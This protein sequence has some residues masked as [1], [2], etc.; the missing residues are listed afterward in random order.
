MARSHMPA[1]TFALSLP[2]PTSPHKQETMSATTTTVAACQTHINTLLATL[3]GLEREHDRRIS[4]SSKPRLLAAATWRLGRARLIIAE[5]LSEGVASDDAR[6]GRKRMQAQSE[7]R[8]VE[9][10]REDL[11]REAVE[12]REKREGYE[13]RIEEWRRRM[14][15]LV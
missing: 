8:L 2:P 15:E 5:L 6:L 9:E 11:R 10:I 12:Y 7:S 4:I 13:R 3:A 1:Y 14:E